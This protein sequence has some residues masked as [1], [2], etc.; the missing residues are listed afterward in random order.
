MTF[1]HDKYYDCRIIGVRH[2]KLGQNQADALEF[3][4]RFADGSQDGVAKF[5]TEKALQYTR[6]VLLDLGCTADDITGNDWIR[7]INARL[8]DQ[9]AQVHAK[10]EGKYGVRLQSIYPRRER[11][12]TKEVVGAPSPFGGPRSRDEFGGGMPDDQDV[13]F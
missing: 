2:I 5:L 13:P 11:Q 6:Q 7:K 1:E 12:S 10:S 4:V 8:A 9:K 3:A